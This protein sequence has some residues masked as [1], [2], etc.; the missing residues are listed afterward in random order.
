MSKSDE[1]DFLKKESS[2]RTSIG[3]AKVGYYVVGGGVHDWLSPWSFRES[4]PKTGPSI[5]I[6]DISFAAGDYS[7]TT[8]REL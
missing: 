5:I 4:W 1:A 3:L 7:T 6:V 2:V 8:S